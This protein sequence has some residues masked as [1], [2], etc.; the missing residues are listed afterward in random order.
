MKTNRLFIIVVA[1]IFCNIAKS[2]QYI[3]FDFENG[4]WVYGYSNSDLS[5]TTYQYFCNGD[6]IINSEKFYKLFQYKL[7]CPLGLCLPSDTISPQFKTYIRNNDNKQV[8]YL[9]SG[10]EKVLYDFNLK[11]GDTIINGLRGK[12]DGYSSDSYIIVKNIDSALFCGKYHKRYKTYYF[13]R[14]EDSL[15]LI[16]GLGFD[17]CLFGKG[18]LGCNEYCDGGCYT[19]KNN[20]SCN[21][22]NCQLLVGINQLPT[23]ID[24]VQIFPNPSNSFLNLKS[25]V[26]INKLVILDLSGR[27]VYL[28]TSINSSNVKVNIEFLN[29]GFYLIKIESDTKTIVTKNFIKIK[30]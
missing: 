9:D 10:K 22:N 6:T 13:S 8:V 19:E 1:M 16:E 5:S 21:N 26:G 15:A 7:Y 2:Q 18:D 17:Q 28:N 24:E 3:P 12:L 4:I 30:Q 11:V 29:E 20:A 27:P 25:E 14:Y 23:L